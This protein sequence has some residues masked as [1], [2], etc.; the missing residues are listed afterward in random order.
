MPWQGPWAWHCYL[1]TLLGVVF[2]P[3]V[4]RL[5][6]PGFETSGQRFDLACYHAAH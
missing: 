1:V 3:W 6:A 2:A 5:F 4:V